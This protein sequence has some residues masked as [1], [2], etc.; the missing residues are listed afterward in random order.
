MDT[1]TKEALLAGINLLIRSPDAHA[2]FNTMQAAAAL[3]GRYKEVRLSGESEPLNTLAILKSS[4]PDRYNAVID[5]IERKRAEA[6]AEPLLTPKDNKFDRNE[7]MQQFMVQKRLRE[8]RAVEIENMLREP[9]DRLIGRARLD[10]MQRKASEWKTARDDLIAEAKAGRGSRLTRDE[11]NKILSQYWERI[12]A[13]L[14]ALEE[15]ARR[16]LQ[17][18]TSRRSKSLSSLAELDAALRHNP[19]A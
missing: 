5:L 17:Q 6:G 7:Y 11:T 2:M 3:I 8:R 14:D 15:A 13:Q 16:E 19:Y 1:D 18:P 4:H 9:R 10:Y 12:D